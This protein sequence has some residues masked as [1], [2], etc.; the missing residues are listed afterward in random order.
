[1]MITENEVQ[2]E[3]GQTTAR[4]TARVTQKWEGAWADE[5][6]MARWLQLLVRAPEGPEQGIGTEALGVGTRVDRADAEGGRKLSEQQGWSL[7]AC[8]C[9]SPLTAQGRRTPAWRVRK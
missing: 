2:T 3:T 8:G 5:K 6:L 1:M 7:P 9:A 4:K